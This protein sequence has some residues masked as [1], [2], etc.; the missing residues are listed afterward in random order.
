MGAH[1]DPKGLA[2]GSGCAYRGSRLR[3]D[4]RARGLPSPLAHPRPQTMEST[5]IPSP[6]TE[7]SKHTAATEGRPPTPPQPFQRHLMRLLEQLGLGALHGASNS[8]PRAT[9]AA[10]HPDAGAPGWGSQSRP[11]RACSSGP[12]LS[13]PPSGAT[14][15]DVLV[16]AANHGDAGEPAILEPFTPLHIDA[17]RQQFK[18]GGEPVVQEDPLGRAQRG[19]DLAVLGGQPL[20]RLPHVVDR[21]CD[22][23]GR[24]G[25]P[26]TGPH[27]WQCRAGEVGRRGAALG[28]VATVGSGARPGVGVPV[29]VQRAPVQFLG[30]APAC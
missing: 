13:E 27:G 6:S 9:G 17:T 5:L 3:H 18:G 23:G 20:G 16:R 2:F 25:E 28:L 15:A 29:H 4:P 21:R 19:A 10:R 11:R 8:D 12:G 7:P 30:A 14:V 26:I 24:L 1:P 22:P